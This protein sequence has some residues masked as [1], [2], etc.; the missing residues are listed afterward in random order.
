MRT[1]AG[2]SRRSRLFRFPLPALT[3]QQTSSHLPLAHSNWIW[4]FCI[5]FFTPAI[6][7]NIQYKYGFV[8]AGA[9][10]LN[11]IIAYLF[12]YETQALTLE[13][14]DEMYNSG[15]PAWKSTSWVPEGY[16]SREEVKDTEKQE[17]LKAT[18]VEDPKPEWRARPD[19]EAGADDGKRKVPKTVATTAESASGSSE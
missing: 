11:F 17:D 3:L 4:N 1:V 8:F 19:D 15:V 14:V 7:A 9:N 5:G 6:T 2:R 10:A 18:G 12:V 16:S 13:Q